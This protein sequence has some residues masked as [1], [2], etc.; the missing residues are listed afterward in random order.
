M[1]EYFLDIL[2]VASLVILYFLP[3]KSEKYRLFWLIPLTVFLLNSGIRIYLIYQKHIGSERVAAL[4]S[5]VTTTSTENK[6]L[7]EKIRKIKADTFDQFQNP[8]QHGGNRTLSRQ[9]AI[10]EH[11]KEAV[12]FFKQGKMIEA[13]DTIELILDKDPNH[14]NSLNLIGVIYYNQNDKEKALSYFEKALMYSGNDELSNTVSRNIEN[15][16]NYPEQE[17][18]IEIIDVEK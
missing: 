10:S 13:K 7:R 3:R 16:K 2:F 8:G 4:Q 6:R 15:I 9:S 17:I 11:Y 14:A 18:P 12:N 1:K 5:Q